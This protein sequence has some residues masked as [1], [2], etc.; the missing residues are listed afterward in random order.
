MGA[1]PKQQPDVIGAIEAVEFA[2]GRAKRGG[3]R[4][5]VERFALA[6]SSPLREP[7]LEAKASAEGAGCV[8]RAR[9][10]GH[11]SSASAHAS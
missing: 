3:W 10:I 7:V 11:V 4:H 2:V 6:A 5:R 8:F 9:Q 1:V